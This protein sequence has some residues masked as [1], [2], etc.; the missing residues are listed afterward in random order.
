[1]ENIELVLWCVFFGFV[2]GYLYRSAVENMRK[3]D[4]VH[5]CELYKEQGCS[6]VDGMLCDFPKCSML[7][8]Y[9]KQKD[10]S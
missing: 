9:R 2:I 4:P 5:G 6:H 7:N 3:T 1:M 10:E 8:D